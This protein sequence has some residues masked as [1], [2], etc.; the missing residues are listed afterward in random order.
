MTIDLKM[1]ADQFAARGIVIAA[2]F[3][4]VAPPS[5]R[6]SQFAPL[7]APDIM[8]ALDLRRRQRWRAGTEYD[9]FS[10]IWSGTRPA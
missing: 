6:Y 7:H 1:C 4:N 8:S 3:C 10:A 9:R 2:A 5:V